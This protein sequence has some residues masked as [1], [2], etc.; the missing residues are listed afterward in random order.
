LLVAVEL[1][2]T[3]GALAVDESAAAA[4]FFLG[5][6]AGAVVVVLVELAELLVVGGV[7]CAPR[8]AMARTTVNSP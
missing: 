2:A 3:A 7:V 1:L 4:L 5:F 6:F 8:G